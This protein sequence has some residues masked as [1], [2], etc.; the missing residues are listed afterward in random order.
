MVTK[1][2]RVKATSTNGMTLSNALRVVESI[3]LRRAEQNPSLLIC[4]NNH[5]QRTWVMFALLLAF[6]GSSWAFSPR[7]CENS[8]RRNV[9][10][11]GVNRYDHA[12]PPAG[13][14]PQKLPRA[15]H[16]ANGQEQ[17]SEF[18]R[19]RIPRHVAFVCDGNSRWAKARYLPASAGHAAG[20]DRMLDC[21][22]TL[23]RAGVECCTMYGFSTENWKRSPNEIC[24]ILSLIERIATSYYQRALD[25]NIR[26]K[27][28]GDIDD[29]RIPDSLRKA[30]QKLERDTASDGKM[31]LTVCLAVN[32]GGRSDI[33]NASLRLAQAIAAGEIDP[34]TVSEDDFS[35]MLCTCGVPD[36]DLVI[37]TGGEK[38]LS[39]FLLFNVAYAELFFTDLLWPEFDA[40]HLEEALGWFASRSRRFGG[41]VSLSSS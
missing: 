36:P 11:Q 3:E 41:R 33:I 10:P 31:Q 27:I 2:I 30:L 1:T 17:D 8:L 21:L 34:S 19:S 25:D 22:T 13:A 24:D 38:R 32:Y 28:L 20:A 39:N 40:S 15:A 26:V 16:H 9:G 35:A 7:S 23:Q 29:A 12:T 18:T 5:F 14:K 4:F 37:R 6:S